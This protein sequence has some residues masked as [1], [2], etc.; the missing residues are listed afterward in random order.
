[1]VSK[2]GFQG[3][4][5]LT[6][7]LFSRPR[8]GFKAYADSKLALMMAVYHEQLDDVDHQISRVAIHPGVVKTRIFEGKTLGMKLVAKIM[9]LFSTTP[10]KGCETVV[11]LAQTDNIE[12]Y[13]GALVEKKYYIFPWPEKVKDQN[14]YKILKDLTEDV[15]HGLLL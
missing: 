14:Q 6:P 8:K 9:G 10:V 3:K 7:S 5:S 2:A 12:K 11:F 1:M 15:F 13:A 4:L